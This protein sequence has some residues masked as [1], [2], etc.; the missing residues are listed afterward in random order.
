MQTYGTR[1]LA[2]CAG[3]H[4]EKEVE[5]SREGFRVGFWFFDGVSLAGNGQNGKAEAT[6]AGQAKS[7]QQSCRH[8]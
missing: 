5:K 3:Y 6:E 7:S 2:Q 1:L 4:F 8:S